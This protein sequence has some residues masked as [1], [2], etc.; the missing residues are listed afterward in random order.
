MMSV[1]ISR[2]VATCLT[3][4][5][6]VYTLPSGTSFSTTLSSSTSNRYASS[7]SSTSTSTSTNG[8]TTG[9]LRRRTNG[10][11]EFLLLPSSVLVL[12]GGGATKSA[13]PERE[14]I[15]DGDATVTQLIFN[16]V[17]GIVGAGVL[18]L[19]AGIS[20]YSSASSGYIP[21]VA[22]ITV[23]GAM[24]GYCFALIGRCCA[25]TNTRS[26]RD[27]WSATIGTETSWLPAT[28]VTAMTCSAILA[29]SMFLGDTLV[30]LLSTAGI[31]TTK[32]PVTLG[33]TGLVL[34][35]LCLMKNLSSLAPFSLVGSLGM[36]YTTIAMAFRYFSGAYLP[37]GKFGMDM[38]PSLRPKFGSVGAAG[39]FTP[40]AAIMVSMLST[41]FTAHFNA[42]KFYIELKDKTLPK[43]YQVVSTSFAISV[44]IFALVASLGFLTFG[45]HS[46]GL[47][48]NNYSTKDGLMSLS[49]IAVAI[50]LIFSYPLA[51]VG[52]RDGFLDLLKIKG[53]AKSQ[54]T[55]T[56]VL[57]SAITFLALIAPDVSFVMAFAG[58]IFGNSLIYIF[59]ALMFRGAIKKK[60]DATQK[61]QL[62]SKLAIGSVIAGLSMGLL[63][64]KMAIS[65]L[66]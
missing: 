33:L 20:A 53:T 54:N 63:G 57:L 38:A 29:Y 18:S 62:E 56:V 37:T 47:I 36:V 15:N 41:A 58:A 32:V 59:P 4:F 60:A 24:S 1:S 55:L 31:V 34:L 25:Y 7:T 66:M 64:A 13:L 40:A 45:S 17:K 19:P 46:S 8:I 30:S 5:L 35:P 21:A 10:K 65:T 42:P 44:L 43:Y 26:Y 16:L 51:F 50:S 11:G 27:A 23:L 12:R 6:F 9:T 52:A 14:D 28:V 48:L 3:T 39:I 2:L 49:R 61:Q 22:L